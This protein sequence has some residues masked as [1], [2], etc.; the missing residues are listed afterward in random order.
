MP[1]NGQCSQWFHGHRGTRQGDPLSPYLFLI[2]MCR[3]DIHYDPLNGNS[4]EGINIADGEIWFSQFADD[5]AF[6]VDGTR[7]YF[8]SCIYYN[9]LL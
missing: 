3:N 9:D 4:V 7:D 6:F 1:V 2:I 5:T 8:C